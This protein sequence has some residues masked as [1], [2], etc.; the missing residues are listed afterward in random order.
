MY[1]IIWNY[2]NHG[3][4]HCRLIQYLSTDDCTQD[5]AYN[6]LSDEYHN[7]MKLIKNITIESLI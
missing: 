2:I 1:K 3:N 6:K 7:D 4:R 5:Y